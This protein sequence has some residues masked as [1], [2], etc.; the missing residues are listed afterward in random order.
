MAKNNEQLR[1]WV[2]VERVY[3][4]N[5]QR[6]DLILDTR[7]FATLNS[8]MTASLVIKH[9]LG[10]LNDVYIHI[11]VGCKTLCLSSSVFVLTSYEL[12]S[13][14]REKAKTED[15]EEEED[16]E[17]GNSFNTLNFYICFVPNIVLQSE[18]S[19]GHKCISELKIKK[20]W[21]KA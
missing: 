2:F 1:H 13:D 16:E 20:C 3:S 11:N 12:K 15:D 5:W 8:H 6:A 19:R 10:L 7:H 18:Y 17:E 14:V 21:K 4:V 9:S